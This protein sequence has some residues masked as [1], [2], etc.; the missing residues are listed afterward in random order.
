M[1]IGIVPEAT[2]LEALVTEAPDGVRGAGAAAGVQQDALS[3]TNLPLLR[4]FFWRRQ[5]DFVRYL[6]GERMV[7]DQ[8]RLPIGHKPPSPVK[9]TRRQSP[10]LTIKNLCFTH[11]DIGRAYNRR[12]CGISLS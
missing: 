5:L 6:N 10:S 11:G 3:L 12:G 2:D 1:D 7:T 8:S 4:G 9:G